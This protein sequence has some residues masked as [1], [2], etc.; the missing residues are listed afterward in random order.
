MFTSP[1]PYSDLIFQ[2]ATLQLL[3]LN[4]SQRNYRSYLGHDF[5]RARRIVDC[6]AAAPR[7][8][9]QMMTV[10]LPLILLLIV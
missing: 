5:L 8:Q 3:T 1:E 2:D 4:H 9:I 6:Y 7:I 10:L